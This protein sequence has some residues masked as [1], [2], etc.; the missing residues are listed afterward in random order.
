MR[1]LV[2]LKWIEAD[3]GSSA[4]GIGPHALLT[5]TAYLD[6]DPALP[7]A[8]DALEDLRE[9]IGHTVHFARRDDGHVLYLA[10][11]SPATGTRSPGWAADFPPV[12]RRSARRCWRS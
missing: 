11:R 3:T 5:G 2:E 1:T 6:K 12:S 7:L 9:E 8:H 10:T 4:Y